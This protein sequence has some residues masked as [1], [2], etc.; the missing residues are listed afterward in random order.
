MTTLP[1]RPARLRAR[2]LPRARAAL[3]LSAATAAGS[4][5]AAEPRAPNE[6]ELHS[7]Y[8]VSVVRE[9]IGLQE[10]LI[11][12]SSEAASNAATP[13]LRQQ[14]LDTSAELL[15]RLQKLEAVLGRLQA[16]MLPRIAALD[17]LALGA[18]I[19]RGDADFQE[20]RAMADR[21]ATQCDAAHTASDQLA[22]CSASCSDNALL[23]RVGAC[24]DPTWLQ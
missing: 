18:A 4:L 10:H 24:D 3:L 8:C 1:P 19:R 14:W 5:A 13:E 9:E 7:M 15:Q 21:C 23:A 22:A 20:S 2:G 6:N 11:D 12:S 16:Y 17:A